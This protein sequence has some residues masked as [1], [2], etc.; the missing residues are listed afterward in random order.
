MGTSSLRRPI[1]APTVTEPVDRRP[2]RRF[3]DAART[4]NRE[5]RLVQAARRTREWALG[6]EQ[7]GDR[8]TTARER[9]S[10]LAVRH[11]AALAGSEPG[12]F[13]ELG[14]SAVQAWQRLSESQGRGRGEVEVAVLFTDLVGF[15]DWALAS[16]DDLAIE[17]LKEVSEA[18]EPA[19]VSRRGEIVKRLGDGL[20]GAF[21]DAPSAIE[22]ALEACERTEAIELDGYRPRLRGGIHL[23]RPR[24]IGGDY[25]GVDVNIAAR[26][27]QAARP[28]EVLVSDRT[29]RALD[30]E[31]ISRSE[32]RPFS[33]KGAPEDLVAHAVRSPP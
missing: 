4:L 26:L 9:P 28:G 7:V 20:M 8:L 1:Y 13:G 22:A 10:D 12:V 5:P 19:I 6:S 25:F 31:A 30:E 16:G 29:L 18:T 24:K 21:A 2:R 14:L 32:E 23:G 15:S 33:A 27:A 11:V 17:L 3:V